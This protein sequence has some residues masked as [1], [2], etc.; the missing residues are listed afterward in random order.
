M[1]QKDTKE[2]PNKHLSLVVSE[3]LSLPHLSQREDS[4]S[5]KSIMLLLHLQREKD[6]NFLLWT[7]ETLGNH[8]PSCLGRANVVPAGWCEIC[9]SPYPSS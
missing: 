4:G 3:K 7:Q 9:C 6:F 2:G 8:I 5:D 1:L